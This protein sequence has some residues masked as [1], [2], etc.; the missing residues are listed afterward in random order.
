MPFTE[1]LTVFF[2]P[3]DFGIGATIGASSVNGIFR[4]EAIEVQG[5]IGE[6][7]TF[8]CRTVDVSSVTP[9]AAASISGTNYIVRVVLPDGTGVTRMI[10][11]EA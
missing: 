6:R 9:G 4:H 5:V 11:E 7:P 1:D 8:Q 3:D 2:D 10:L